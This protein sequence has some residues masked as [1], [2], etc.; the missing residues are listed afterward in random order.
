M[1]APLRMGLPAVAASLATVRRFLREWLPRSGLGPVEVED[2]V[3]AVSE[4]CT[5][6]VEHGYRDRPG[7]VFVEA[8][9]TESDIHILV[10]DRGRWVPP[11]PEV[12]SLR[13]RGLALMRALVPKVTV[14]TGNSGTSVELWVPLPG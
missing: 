5:N 7:T 13:G 11:H 1:P 3:L 14:H 2:V 9:A 10:R 8:E 4:A 12:N 6:A